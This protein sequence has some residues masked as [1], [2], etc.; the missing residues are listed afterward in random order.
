ML[1]SHKDWQ[2][3]HRSGQVPHARCFSLWGPPRNFWARQTKMRKGTEIDVFCV[4][5][6]QGK[7]LKRVET[8]N[9]PMRWIW[10]FSLCF[11]P[12]VLFRTEIVRILAE[13]VTGSA[14]S[15]ADFSS[16]CTWLPLSRAEQVI[17]LH[18]C[19]RLVMEGWGF[20]PLPPLLLV[21][22]CFAYEAQ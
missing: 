12:A 4:R 21:V 11:L 8:K 2:L 1:N 6:K 14:F 7:A 16:T 17:P 20:Q 18:L 9:S 13:I 19:R 22:S 5:W 15:F 3:S 10:L